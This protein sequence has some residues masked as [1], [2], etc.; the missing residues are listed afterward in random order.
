MAPSNQLSLGALTNQMKQLAESAGGK[1][2][3]MSAAT[4]QQYLQ[5]I[6]E[7]RS[8]L[9]E[10]YGNAAQLADYGNVPNLASAHHTKSFLTN[11]VQG[12]GGL[13]PQLKQYIAY[14]D[15]FEKTV[16]AAF[17]RMQA[18]DAGGDGGTPEFPV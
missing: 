13:L 3:Q 12:A 17:G 4:H 1:E 5:L 2:F 9:T 6:T 11:D 14:L 16:N 15:E 10:Q 7:Y 8:A 18:E